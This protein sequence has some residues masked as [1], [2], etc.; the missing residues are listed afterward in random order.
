MVTMDAIWDEEQIK[1]DIKKVKKGSLSS[2]DKQE[3]INKLRSQLLHLLSVKYKKLK[4][5]MDLL[6]ENTM[7]QEK[8]KKSIEWDMV[9]LTKKNEQFTFLKHARENKDNHLSVKGSTRFY[10]N[11]NCVLSFCGG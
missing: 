5:N 9:E 4:E 8:Y 7:K 2:E 1:S 11:P 10:Q 3:S 6:D